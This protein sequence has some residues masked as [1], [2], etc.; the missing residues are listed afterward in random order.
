MAWSTLA[1]VAV[2][3][4][5]LVY[6]YY[7]VMKLP[8]GVWRLF[9][10]LPLIAF[11]IYM[12][13]KLAT[14]FER[15]FVSFLFTWLTTF[16]LLL[17]CWDAGPAADPW[18][19]STFPRFLAVISLSLQLKTKSASQARAAGGSGAH[20]GLWHIVLLRLFLKFL[21]LALLSSIYSFR[22]QLPGW[23]IYMMYSF[24]I[25]VS[26]SLVFDGLAMIVSAATGI[27]LEPAYNKPFLSSSLTDFWGKRWNLL[28]SNLMRTAVYEPVLY[29]YL[30]SQRFS[31]VPLWP[32]TLALI[33]CFV[34][35]GLMHE[36][37]FVYISLSWPTG[38]VTAFFTL[39]GILAALE[40]VI[41]RRFRLKVTKL[42][43][44]PITLCF[45][46]FSS[47]WLFYP[48][49]FRAGTEEQAMAEF[50]HFFCKLLPENG[51]S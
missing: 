49:L 42:V 51:C 39:H 26:C 27:E 38:E 4:V 24:H 45:L 30:D 43:S 35:S 19:F 12:P 2:S 17:L 18:G 15:G 8:K 48:P 5:G 21:F 32:R 13:L 44:I 33:S 20:Q 9:A 16:K 36:L 23:L 50:Q 34:V 7:G 10:L 6:V 29:V 3:S 22:I 31:Q 25:Y 14:V 40:V 41:R 37:L 46:F 47:I 28:V 1:M 11:Y